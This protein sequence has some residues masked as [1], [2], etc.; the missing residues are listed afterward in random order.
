MNGTTFYLQWNGKY[1]QIFKMNK[2][3]SGCDF[4]KKAKFIFYNLHY[5]FF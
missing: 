5:Y 2:I 3:F 4:L 1:N